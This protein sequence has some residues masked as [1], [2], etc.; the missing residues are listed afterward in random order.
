MS[1]IYILRHEEPSFRR[2][3]FKEALPSYQRIIPYIAKDSSHYP[4]N[5]LRI[6]G[7]S[8]VRTTHVFVS[9]VDVWPSS[10]HVVVPSKIQRCSTRICYSCLK[11]V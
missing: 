11:R 9:D 1:V 7:M 4:I 3:L 8:Q 5:E 10:K 2:E 6:I